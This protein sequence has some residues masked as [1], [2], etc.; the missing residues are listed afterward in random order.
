[1][2]GDESKARGWAFQSSGSP[3]RGFHC[4]VRT[5]DW[6]LYSDG[7]L[8]HVKH[9]LLGASP[10]ASLESEPVRRKLQLIMNDVLVQFPDQK[11]I[12]EPKNLPQITHKIRPGD[13]PEMEKQGL[14]KFYQKKKSKRQG[15]QTRLPNSRNWADF[16]QQVKNR[17]GQD[18]PPFM[19]QSSRFTH[20][21]DHAP[22][23]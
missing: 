12:R 22:S 8:F 20:S 19:E 1:M 13:Y 5:Q 3:K 17:K 7:R 11:I 21:A 6:K 2:K 15:I 23:R 16:P 9:D 18:I 14:I 10:V 4:W